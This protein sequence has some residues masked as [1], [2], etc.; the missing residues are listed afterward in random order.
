M[1]IDLVF[2]ALPP[3]L[4]G[5]GDHTARLAQA[6]HR[7][8]CDVRIRTAQ[9]EARPIEGIPITTDYTLQPPRGI[10]ALA[11]AVT[12]DPPD[13]LF[14]QFNQFSYGQYGF[15]PW[16][17]LTL[18]RIRRRVPHTKIAWMAHED[19]VPVISW[20]FALMTL[21]QRVQFYALGHQAD[22]IFFS[23]DPWVRQ[24]ASW[25]P[26]TPV[27]HLP[28]GSNIPRVPSSRSDARRQ[29]NIPDDTFVAGIFGT[30]A[31]NARQ[32]PLIADT[33]KALHA[34]TP[35]LHI[36]Y[37]G[38]HGDLLRSALPDLPIHDAGRLPEDDVS[39]HLR[40]MDLHLAPFVDGLSTRRG[41][42]MASLQ[43]GIATLSTSG[44]L[45]DQMLEAVNGA[46]LRLTP[47]DD[48]DAFVQAALSL[49]HN[50]EQR[51]ALAGRGR[52]FFDDTF[53]WDVLAQRVVATLCDTNRAS[54]LPSSPPGGF[55]P[56]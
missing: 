46:A 3:A 42:A 16:L 38:P 18:R 51:A 45:T 17:P 41:S 2:P 21:W 20:K 26:D 28:V 48:A 27:T 10:Q 13:W 6:L 25:F 44:P 50:P 37:V 47:V 54:R 11:D 40:A 24:Y 8:G 30:L 34:E 36:L 55:L 35:S 15:N 56:R 19:F 12:A 49:Y 43:H 5:I 9:S 7:T 4:D 52:R 1:R 32:L 29:L 31:G 22:H 39:I 33:L 53:D 23:I 14:V